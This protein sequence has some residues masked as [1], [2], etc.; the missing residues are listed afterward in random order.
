MSTENLHMKVFISYIQNLE[1]LEA[2]NKQ[3]EKQ[4]LI[5]L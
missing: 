3:M 5:H 1:E 2:T 4:T